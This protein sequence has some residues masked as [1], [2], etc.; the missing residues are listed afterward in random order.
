MSDPKQRLHS[1]SQAISTAV[2]LLK[3]ELPTMQAFLEETRKMESFGPIV[4]PTLY[5]NSERR[6]V[7]AL[8][9]PLFKAAVTFVDAYDAQVAKAKDA[10]AKVNQ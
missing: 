9:E 8:M 7:S 10:L 1:A 5:K 4:D 2:T 3:S 6:A